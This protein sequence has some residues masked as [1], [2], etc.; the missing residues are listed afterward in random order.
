MRARLLLLLL[1]TAVLYA[2][3]LRFGFTLDDWWWL[4][5]L[6]PPAEVADVVG[7]YHMR[8]DDPRAAAF[9]QEQGVAPWWAVE[10]FRW[11]LFRPAFVG[12]MELLWALFGAN[13]LPWHVLTLLAYLGLVALVFVL[14]R[15]VLG[16]PTAWV[17]TTV[18]AL[19]LSHVQSVWFISNA[20][21]VLSAIAG[22][23]GLLAH[24]R[25]RE[26]GWGLG[27]A[28]SVLA[29]GVGLILGESA[30]AILAYIATYELV[31]REG[32]L[33]ERA[34]AVLP[35]GL[36]AAAYLGIHRMMGYGTA[37]NG[38]YQDPTGQ[39]SELMLDLSDRWVAIGAG[40][41]GVIPADLWRIAPEHH[42]AITGAALFVGAHALAL[43]VTAWGGLSA[44]HRRAVFWMTTGAVF[45]LLPGMAAVT[46]GRLLLLSTVGG[47]GL[48]GVLLHR[49]W[50]G[51]RGE[52]AVSRRWAVAASP[53]ALSTAL[54]P[55]VIPLSLLHVGDATA[56]LEAAALEVDLGPL[57]RDVVLVTM[58]TAAYTYTLPTRTARGL[59]APKGWWVLSAAERPQRLTRTGDRTLELTVLEGELFE[60]AFERLFR[61][62]VDALRVGDR[63]TRS[64]FD[65]EVLGASRLAFHFRADLA[66]LTLLTW[67]DGRLRPVALPPVGGSVDLSAPTTGLGA[68]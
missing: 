56:A 22:V 30:F 10:E 27:A 4:V 1:L 67:E 29:L 33:A 66:D 37:H 45:S 12:L 20:H 35:I 60:A 46:S 39:L 5:A 32:P 62:P 19:H 3:A 55:L 49:A 14:H 54:A 68:L 48:L 16:E 42:A 11:V 58:P 21:S 17:A 2:P 50:R 13:P 28:M 64:L 44:S 40:V 7:P 57:E 51:L 38:L 41:L 63:I 34:R 53:F 9:W 59:P 52:G 26:E 23:L 24:L 31:G 25:W 43:I 18:F 65:V 47:S 8:L 15:R 61:P 6:H 36:L